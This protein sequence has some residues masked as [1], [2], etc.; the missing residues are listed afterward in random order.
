MRDTSTTDLIRSLCIAVERRCRAE[1]ILKLEST[2]KNASTVKARQRDES[3][4]LRALNV[5]LKECVKLVDKSK[6]NSEPWHYIFHPSLKHTLPARVIKGLKEYK[7]NRP[8][9][10]TV[11]ELLRIPGI[12]VKGLSAI[13]YR[14]YPQ[15][16]EVWPELEEDKED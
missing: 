5:H 8:E 16:P 10:R 14:S 1:D 11:E 12:G 6:R 2:A 3:N 15:A 9:Q 7:I 4:A 13:A